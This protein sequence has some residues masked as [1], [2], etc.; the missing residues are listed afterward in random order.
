MGK[1]A[2]L[3]IAC[4]P[5]AGGNTTILLE[6]A[7]AGAASAGAGTELIKLT[8]YPFSPCRACDGC[9]KN[10]LCVIKDGAEEIFSKML[11]ADRF[12]LAAPIF[13]MGLNAQAKALIDRSQRFWATR[14]ILRQ[15]VIRDA[16]ARP[17]RRGIF[18]SA[19]GTG[20][21]GVFDGAKRTVKYFF[22]MLEIKPE[23]DYCYPHTDQKGEIKN[24]PAAL[25]EVHRAG[26][27][28]ALP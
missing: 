5:R 13:S 11:E 23:G 20:L 24:N 9:F 2:C 15:Q 16:A 14:Y 26:K 19:A 4:S 27:L 3:G 25:E 12:I 21:Q 28:L 6:N 1:I 18:I 17:E 8:D 7:L 22:K 10:G